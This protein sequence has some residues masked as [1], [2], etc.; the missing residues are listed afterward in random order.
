MLAN[1]RR[2]L[3]PVALL[4]SI[5]LSGCGVFGAETAELEVRRYDGPAITAEAGTGWTATVADGVVT[6]KGEGLE[7]GVGGGRTAFITATAEAG[8]LPRL[9][10]V[11]V[12][13]VNG[14]GAT[15]DEAVLEV[16]DWSVPGVLSGVLVGRASWGIGSGLHR[17]TFW[18]EVE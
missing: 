15:F 14:V 11:W 1:T 10:E 5:A 17:L 4:I 13:Q 12:G 18:V 7:A 9:K 3:A 8:D 2:H 16:Q 6:L